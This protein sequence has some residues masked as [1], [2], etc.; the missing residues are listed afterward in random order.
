VR[1][2]QQDRDVEEVRWPRGTSQ[3]RERSRLGMPVPTKLKGF[4]ST[5][6]QTG[7]W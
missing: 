4:G 6:A 2:H 7:D 3:M 5:H 1:W